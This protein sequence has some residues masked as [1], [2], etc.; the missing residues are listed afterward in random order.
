ML[1]K[2][3]AD[4]EKESL[5]KSSYKENQVLITTYQ[6][7]RLIT[8]LVGNSMEDLMVFPTNGSMLGTIHIG[9]IQ[10]VSKTIDSFFVEIAD[11]RVCFLPGRNIIAPVLLNREYDGRLLEGDIILIQIER[12]AVKTKDAVCTTKLTFNGKYVILTTGSNKPGF[13]KKYTADQRGY[14]VAWHKDIADTLP[15][16]CVPFAPIYRTECAE[17]LTAKKSEPEIDP[18]EQELT[19]FVNTLQTIVTKEI[20]KSL[21]SC[22][23]APDPDYYLFLRESLSGG[24]EEIVIDDENVYSFL[25]EKAQTGLLADD[26]IRFYQD[27]RIGMS[28]LYGIQSK[29]DE[30]LSK[31]VWLKSGGNLVIEPTEA[32]TVI[33]VNTGRFSAKH[34]G[35]DQTYWKINLEAAKEALRQIRLR[36]ISGMILIDFINMKKADEGRLLKTV[37][38]LCE[39]EKVST[40]VYDI[41]KLGI[42]ELT[43]KKIYK[44]LKE[45]LTGETN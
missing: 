33:D 4:Q 38:E 44:T 31:S 42:M 37:R 8:R 35:T 41:T 1:I 34:L 28:A 26:K 11:K 40:E 6:G 23:Y 20:H 7:K 14:F 15:T 19:F 21:Y 39:K 3:Y 16:L 13:S 29:M 43:R 25:H 36:N 24:Y 30:V 45:S 10:K 18:L 17:L 32:L 9:R 2:A 22:I 27:E 5:Q 12:D